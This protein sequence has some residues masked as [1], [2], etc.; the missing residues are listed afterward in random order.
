MAGKATIAVKSLR[1]QVDLRIK[2]AKRGIARAKRSA[3]NTG[4]GQKAAKAS[5]T[6]KGLAHGEATLAKLEQ[7]Q[8]LLASCCCTA[9][10][11]C[12]FDA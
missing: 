9:S 7:A 10:Q 1:K 2:A 8:R 5:R 4:K 3:K 11:N 12:E 6:G